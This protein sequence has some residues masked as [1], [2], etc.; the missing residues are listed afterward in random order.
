MSTTMCL[1]CGSKSVPAGRDGCGSGPAAVPPARH[2]R[3]FISICSSRSHTIA[4]P[5]VLIVAIS[6]HAASEH[7]ADRRA[8]HVAG[9]GPVGPAPARVADLQLGGD[10]L[11]LGVGIER[12]VA[13][14]AAPAG[15]L[16]PAERQCR[17]E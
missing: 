7:D 1:I 13:H 10:G 5:S 3:R 14:L 2:A 9:T 15:L 17:V 4:P 8:R 16:V 6:S 11:D 12:L